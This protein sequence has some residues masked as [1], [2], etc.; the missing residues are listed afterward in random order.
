MRSRGSIG[1]SSIAKNPRNDESFDSLLGSDIS[2]DR[3]DDFELLG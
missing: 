3:L 1:L 2:S